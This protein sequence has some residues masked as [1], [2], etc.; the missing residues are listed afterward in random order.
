M[1]SVSSIRCGASQSTDPEIAAHELAAAIRQEDAALTVFFCSPHYD[2]ER[3]ATSLRRAFAATPLIGCTTAGEISPSAYSNESISGVSFGARDFEAACI[4]L[5]VASSQTVPQAISALRENL[6][7]RGPTLTPA[8]TFGFLLI[9]G[10]SMR[11]EFVASLVHQNLRGIQ[12]LGGSAG[13][14]TRFGSTYVYYNGE[15]HSDA[16][17]L[18]LVRTTLPFTMFRTQHF[19][20]SATKLVVTAADPSRRIVSEING[21]PAGPEFARAVGLDVSQ[22]TPLIFAAHPVV[23]RLGG[24]YYVRSIQKVG[25]DG[26]LTFF[27]AIDAGLVLTVARNLD[28][29][30]GL[31]AAF[32]DVRRR[33]GPPQVVL[34]CDCVLRRLELE[35]RGVK[36]RAAAIFANN[37]AVGFATYGEQF[38]AMHLNQTFVGLA[39]GAPTEIA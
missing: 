25:D 33:I 9:D 28:I 35:R 13:D 34:S 6:T 29:I 15:F 18:T 7:A 5:P 2:R 23:V 19:E 20:P 14:G 30:D 37:N 39:I 32:E 27:C 4:D 11:E 3:L 1:T 24:E 22:L 31:H 12:L 17:L 21:R 16:G 10:L 36:D 8:N 26:S 38:N